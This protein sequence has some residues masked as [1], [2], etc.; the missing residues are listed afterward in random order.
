MWATGIPP[1]YR[2]YQP[3]PLSFKSG[4]C[5]NEIVKFQQTHPSF[6]TGIGANGKE[7]GPSRTCT[8]I[9]WQNPN[10]WRC[11]KLTIRQLVRMSGTDNE[12]ILL[13]PE[14]SDESKSCE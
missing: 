5:R 6:E 7:I 1:A 3:C 9:C 8:K 12:D 2:S 13:I 11:P 4:S 14:R 10:R